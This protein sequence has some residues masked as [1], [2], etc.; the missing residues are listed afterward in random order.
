MFLEMYGYEQHGVGRDR[1]IAV[2]YEY[3][4]GNIVLLASP[5]NHTD[6]SHDNSDTKCKVRTLL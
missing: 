5:M 4:D 2:Q 1:L 3:G 6:I